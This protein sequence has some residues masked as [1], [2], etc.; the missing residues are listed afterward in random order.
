M[1]RL[2]I[3]YQ[4]K[5]FKPA[6]Y[7][8]IQKLKTYFDCT[9]IDNII[10]YNNAINNNLADCVLICSSKIDTIIDGIKANFNAIPHLLITTK[11]NDLKALSLLEFGLKD[12]LFED[13]LSKLIPVINRELKVNK[14]LANSKQAAETLSNY[15]EQAPLATITWDLDFK[16]VSWNKTAE[17]VFGYTAAEAM[18]KTCFE[19]T[20]PKGL[21]ETAS[22]IFKNLLN[23]T[24]K[25]DNVNETLKKGGATF[26]C[27]WH[28]TILK[29][30]DG[31][32]TGIISI[33]EDITE[34][35]AIHNKVLKDKQ[36]LKQA[37]KLS[38]VFN[39]E[40]SLESQKV[41]LDKEFVTLSGLD[42]SFKNYTPKY[43]LAHLI[44]PQDR[45]KLIRTFF[46]AVKSNVKLAV[47]IRVVFKNGT[48]RWINILAD[49]FVDELSHKKSLLGTFID[50]T[51][52]KNELLQL[53]E[54][55]GKLDLAVSIT[56]LGF[57]ILDI[58]TNTVEVSGN[59]QKIFDLNKSKTVF[60]FKELISRV[61]PEDQSKVEKV[62][63]FAIENRTGYQINHRLLLPNSTIIWVNARG[64]VTF[65]KD[66][67]P[68]KLMGIVKD[69]SIQI[70]RERRLLQHSL[71]LNQI[72]SLVL[73]TD[74]N[75]DIIF[76]S[77]SVT[78]QTGF[79]IEEIL[80]QGW[81]DKTFKT[82]KARANSKKFIRNL[83]NDVKNIS[84][85]RYERK[86]ECKYGVAKWF[87]WQ[88]SRGAENTLISVGNDITKEKENVQLVTKLF[89]AI[90]NS[91]TIVVITDKN[92]IIEFVNPKF[93]KVT[94][95][96]FKE[97][98]GLNP[99][100]L[101]TGYT[102][103]AAYKK[104]WQTISSGENWQGEFKNKKKDG[105][106]YWEE[107]IITPVKNEEG[108]ITN[109]IALKEDITEKKAQ[110][111]KFLYALFEAQE[112]EKL[113]FGEILHDNLSQILSA[114]SFFIEAVL[115]PKN[116]KDQLKIE[117]L[118]KIR[119]LTYDAQRESRNISH[120]LMSKQLIES[121][122]VAATIEVCTNYNI[123]KNINFTF[124]NSGYHEDLFEVEIK[125]NIFR[126]IQEI[127]T[128]IVSHSQATKATI[129]FSVKDNEWFILEVNDNGIGIDETQIKENS[130]CFG[131]K[132]IQQ[133]VALLNGIIKRNSKPNMGT[134]YIIKLPLVLEPINSELNL[135]N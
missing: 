91:P 63:K 82:E 89:K 102:T 77:P 5:D 48:I 95:Y 134:K 9:E 79:S 85:L 55:K 75:T 72:S 45:L 111:K 130:K 22:T 108:I 109:Y 52:R 127:T 119:Q 135:L 32:T 10:L 17:E 131:L 129:K 90:E 34:K 94:G 19:L 6:F 57:L 50:I 76:G 51:D 133:R 54:Q 4:S 97:V 30:K 115:N 7:N 47:D 59:T 66:H 81:W 96:T 116:T 105:T 118:Q 2:L 112:N 49:L 11:N 110:E 16:V 15:I 83:F 88:F 99:H 87:S 61:H 20:V 68:D 46:L 43:L 44:H 78:K 24:G 14:A 8:N 35:R 101:S 25:I 60:S 121:G 74:K 53:K 58:K 40:I 86:I 67:K 98:K 31:K 106:V 70:Q 126:I 80:G 38:E 113:K 1:K 12:Y 26:L 39:I 28:N 100:V 29:G 73:V 69:V 124:K 123:S 3:Y 128:N 65:D 18:G 21:V 27:H 107:A 56:Q 41:K 23:Q 13:A 62:I 64:E 33:A 103:K 36:F 114:M 117:Y 84:D 125:Q 122:L 93:E 37:Q 104:M 120:G 71:I 92:G 42:N 132:N